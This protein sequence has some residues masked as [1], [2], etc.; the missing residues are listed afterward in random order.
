[1]LG[2]GNS[3]SIETELDNV[4]NG[5]ARH[6]DSESLLN[7]ENS[8]RKNEI[9]NFFNRNVPIRYDVLGESSEILFGEMNA[10]LSQEMYSQQNNANT[11][12]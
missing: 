11:D 3:N 10:G 6:Q 2:E 9:I 8:S 4:M 12:K 1:M 5:P 7:R